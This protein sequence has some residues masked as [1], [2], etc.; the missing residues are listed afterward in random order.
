MG[1]YNIAIEKRSNTLINYSNYIIFFY[2][3]KGLTRLNFFWMIVFRYFNTYVVI[4]R[5]KR[6]KEKYLKNRLR[7]HI[8]LQILCQNLSSKIKFSVNFSKK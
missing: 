3:R 5:S 4:F 2:V 8:D 6:K 1:G 7:K